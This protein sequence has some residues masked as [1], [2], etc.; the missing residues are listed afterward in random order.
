MGI[1]QSASLSKDE[2][3]RRAETQWLGK[4]FPKNVDR[5]KMRAVEIDGQAG[6]L[7]EDLQP[8]RINVSLRNG[9]ITKI[10]GFY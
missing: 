10:D 2:K 8:E 4:P 5:T 1:A 3:L 6:D 7:R 9:I